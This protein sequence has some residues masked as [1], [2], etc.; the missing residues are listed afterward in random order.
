MAPSHFQKPL[1]VVVKPASSSGV[2]T[3]SAVVGLRPHRPLLLSPLCSPAFRP[4][5]LLGSFGVRASVW[6]LAPSS[7][8]WLKVMT[9]LHGSLGP[10]CA[11]IYIQPGAPGCVWN[12]LQAVRKPLSVHSVFR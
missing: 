12:V 9:S 11:D 2:P 6:L 8:T 7:V 1:R 4:S 3:R 10:S 5:C